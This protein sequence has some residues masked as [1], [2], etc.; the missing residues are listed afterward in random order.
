MNSKVER[1]E[2][3]D[4]VDV[5]L[6]LKSGSLARI[7]RIMDNIKALILRFRDS[8]L[9]NSL[10]SLLFCGERRRCPRI[11][12]N[13][14]M[15]EYVIANLLYWFDWELLNGEVLDMNEAQGAIVQ[16][17]IPLRLVPTPYNH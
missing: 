4:C 7:D 2:E 1:F 15:L 8:P 5:L 3:K 9:D 12:L 10:S 16:K 14:I 11:S 6:H 13:L 17:K